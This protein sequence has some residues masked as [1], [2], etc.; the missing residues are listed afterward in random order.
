M[1]NGRPTDIDVQRER[2]RRMESGDRDD[3]RTRLLVLAIAIPLSVIAL[4]L[5]VI[6]LNLRQ[7][8]KDAFS[9][10]AADVVMSPGG[11]VSSTAK[12]EALQSLFGGRLPDDFAGRFAGGGF[13]I[14]SEAVRAQKDLMQLLAEHPRERGQI[15]DTWKKVFPADE[16][17]NDIPR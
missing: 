8:S 13:G 11:N 3:R 7:Q 16:W 5:V 1:T 9:L 6:A 4:S 14:N 12:A 10:K 17:V 2:R 15:L